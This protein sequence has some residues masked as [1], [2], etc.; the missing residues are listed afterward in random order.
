MEGPFTG[1]SGIEGVGP[2]HLHP[3]RVDQE[4]THI[5]VDASEREQFLDQPAGH[6]RHL[7]VDPGTHPLGVVRE[8]GVFHL[9]AGALAH[10]RLETRHHLQVGGH[11]QSVERGQ[12]RSGAVG[13]GHGLVQGPQ[14]AFG[15]LAQQ[16]LELGQGLFRRACGQQR[17]HG[18]HGVGRPHV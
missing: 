18:A 4:Q 9:G 2:D 15:V 5:G 6:I 7:G 8:V 17:Q 3:Q 16:V 10:A 12:V 13:S 1:L 11:V 14:L